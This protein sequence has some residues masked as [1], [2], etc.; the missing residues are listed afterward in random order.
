MSHLIL[1]LGA[2]AAVAVDEPGMIAT[3]FPG[4]GKLMADLGAQIG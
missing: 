3:S 4:F 2:E 1:G